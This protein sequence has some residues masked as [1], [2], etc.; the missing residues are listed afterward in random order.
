MQFVIK[1][2]KL[3]K[4]QY[5]A[6]TIEVPMGFGVSLTN[7]IFGAYYFDNEN[8]ALEVINSIGSD[9][10]YTSEVETGMSSNLKRS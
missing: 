6:G 7:T 3:S 8:E 2:N 4:P 1:T 9:D 10:Y 5:F